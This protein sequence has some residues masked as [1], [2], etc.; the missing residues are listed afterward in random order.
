MELLEEVVDNFQGGAV[1][2]GVEGRK[3]DCEGV[4]VSQGS[5]ER[6][7]A[8]PETGTLWRGREGRGEKG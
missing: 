1:E 6:I 2:P 5:A 4:R 7:G 3:G 8:R